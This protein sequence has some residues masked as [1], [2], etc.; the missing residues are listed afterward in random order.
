MAQIELRE[1]SQDEGD[2]ILEMIREIGP[3]ENG[4]MNNGY[5]MDETEFKDYLYRNID[6]SNGINL[7]PQRVPQTQYWL[8]VNGYPVGIGKLRH[9]L[10]D[11]LKKFGG[12]IGYCIRP[13]SRGKGFGNIILC[14]LLK[15][16]K[17][18]NIPRARIT[19]K[20]TNTPSKMII[21]YNGGELERIENGECL[22]WI[23]L[24]HSS[25][26]REIHIDDYNDI[27]SLWGKTPGMGLNA[28]D[29][30]ENIQSF[31]IRNKGMSFCFEEDDKI[32]GTILCGHDGR[33]GY[34]YHV[35]VDLDHRGRGIG[36]LL[37]EKSL[38]RLKIE[39]IAKCH[40]FVFADNTSGNAFWA[41]TEWTRREDI[42]VYSKNI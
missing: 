15:K 25:G 18:E 22:F 3:G 40:L 28:A 36:R 27:Y 6:M 33:R 30:W 41:T 14:E 39:G 32:I 21:E 1:L 26:V 12:H 24:A 37:V 7:Q 29:S 4:F 11:N 2:D 42:F 20:E 19:C 5:D 13:N 23:K 10:N 31:L 8:L 16:A 9:Y 35:A 34:I 38:V 17:E